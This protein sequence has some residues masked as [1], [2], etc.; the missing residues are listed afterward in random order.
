MPRY[1]PT[2]SAVEDALRAG[3][4]RA[5]RRVNRTMSKVRRKVGYLDLRK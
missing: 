3:T 4:E 5:Q 1:A 2:K